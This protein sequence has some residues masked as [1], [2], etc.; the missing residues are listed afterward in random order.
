MEQ[1]S[2]SE[3]E[4]CN[5]AQYVDDLVTFKGDSERFEAMVDEFTTMIR[6]NQDEMRKFA[7][8]PEPMMIFQKLMLEPTV[9][10][11]SMF[12]MHDILVYISE[13][14]M[15]HDRAG[16]RNM[17]ACTFAMKDWRPYNRIVDKMIE[18]GEAE[19]FSL[20]CRMYSLFTF[21]NEIRR[22]NMPPEF[23]EFV[24]DRASQLIRGVVAFP[25]EAHLEAILECV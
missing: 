2:E 19:T 3:Q 8:T 16:L 24:T 23:F 25:K 1:G 7:I 6:S 18:N 13:E 14:D 5:A 21:V 9:T 22:R 4:T 12:L 17:I 11:R 10:K 20:A 15:K